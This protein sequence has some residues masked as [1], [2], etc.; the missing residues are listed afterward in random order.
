MVE[1]FAKVNGINICYEIFGEGYPLVLIHGFGANKDEWKLAQVGPLSNHFKV[2]IIDNR[3]AG[4]SD[5]PDEPYLM[6]IFAQDVKK[7]MD[8]LNI[9]KTHILGLSLGGMIAQVFTLDYPERVDKLILINTTPSFPKNPSGIEMYKNSKITKYHAIMEDPIK[10][11]WDYG[12]GG[13]SRSFRKKLQEDPKKMIHNMFTV[14]DLI[15]QSAESPSTPQDSINQTN[16]LL[17]F[18]VTDRLHEIKN[19]TLIITGT[20]DKT[21]PRSL[22]EIIHEKIPKSTFVLLE[23]VGH[24]SAIEKAPEIN[25]HIIKFLRN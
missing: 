10:A 9:E 24:Y 19:E 11:F 2:I 18:D 25:D 14:E 8:H 12:V 15:R 5:R 16:A 13:Y 1:A 20:H 23:K 22:S 21:L 4:K 3:G 6:E 7:L 17:H